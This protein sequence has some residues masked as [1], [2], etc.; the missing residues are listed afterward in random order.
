MSEV[1][2]KDI[3]KVYENG[4]VGTHDVNIT[5]ADFVPVNWAFVEGVWTAQDYDGGSEDG[6]EY[7]VEIVKVDDNTLTLENLWGGEEKLTGTI[8]FDEDANTATITFPARQVVM[9]A[10]AY[11]YGNLLL[12]GQNDAGNWAYA[13]V[14]ASVSIAGISIGPWNMVITDGAYTGYIWGNSYQTELTR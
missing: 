2:L 6:G 5:I 11:G 7:Q 4:Y 13:P 10:S 14:K 3:K 12:I 8:E 9:D 1:I